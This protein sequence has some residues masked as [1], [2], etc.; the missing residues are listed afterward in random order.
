MV[1]P[2]LRTA[3]LA[4]PVAAALAITGG[5]STAHASG[6]DFSVVHVVDFEPTGMASP[7]ADTLV[8]AGRR[9]GANGDTSAVVQ[10]RVDGRWTEQTLS[11]SGARTVWAAADGG[12]VWLLVAPVGEGPAVLWKSTDSGFER[13]GQ[14]PQPVVSVGGFAVDGDTVTVTTTTYN[15]PGTTGPGQAV[16]QYRPSGWSTRQLSFGNG[17][18]RL[19]TTKGGHLV[20][21]EAPGGG[22]SSYVFDLSRDPSV[23]YG[24]ATRTD[25]AN[26]AYGG[27]WTAR[28]AWDF[29]MWGAP[30]PL[31]GANWTPSGG[32]CKRFV[33]G[34]V[35]S[36]PAP[37]FAVYHAEHMVDDRQLITGYVTETNGTQL[38]V[39][40]QDGT[41]TPLTAE[42][43]GIVTATAVSA[44]GTT[45]WIATTG[46]GYQ[47][48]EAHL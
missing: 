42:Y 18:L 41:V 20:V 30:E 13:V 45:A 39:V 37:S 15:A 44:I 12:V 22:P 47:I 14:T 34:D 4:A 8:V 33:N 23:W 9:A 16:I 17:P 31:I 1:R 46:A 36:C 35:Q 38:A 48:E 3:L 43:N 5:A 40:A 25:A 26:V 21:D 10:S 6:H 27:A 2:S 24:P 32:L 29:T 11:A 7:D 19:V 28:N